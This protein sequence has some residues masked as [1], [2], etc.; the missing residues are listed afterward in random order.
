MWKLQVYK[1]QVRNLQATKCTS[2]FRHSWTETGLMIMIVDLI[3]F[4][5]QMFEM[6]LLQDN[7]KV[8]FSVDV[9][10]QKGCHVSTLYIIH[11]QMLSL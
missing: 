9:K 1:L 2:S 11:A 3:D 10:M 5:D 4:D 7:E 6:D 8:T